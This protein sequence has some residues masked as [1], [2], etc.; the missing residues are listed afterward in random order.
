MVWL[1]VVGTVRSTPEY[2]QSL[3]LLLLLLPKASN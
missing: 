2:L 1:P 3:N